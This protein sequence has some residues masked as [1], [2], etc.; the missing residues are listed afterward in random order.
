MKSKTI[1]SRITR[2]GGVAVICTLALTSGQEA[3]A[4]NGQA[5]ATAVAA[6]SALVQNGFNFRDEYHTGLLRRGGK[7]VVRLHLSRGVEYA[8]V[9]AGCRDAYDVDI[10]VYDD[11]WRLI[12]RDTDS[13][14][15]AVVRYVPR[16]SGVFN[17]VVQ[18]Y[19]STRNGAHYILVTG[20]H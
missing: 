5:R 10:M 16:W 13:S 8:L 18:M 1:W 2:W 9:A 19:D 3:V 20:Y 6:A 12:A 14:T 11:S 4:T 15:A 7:K 17:I